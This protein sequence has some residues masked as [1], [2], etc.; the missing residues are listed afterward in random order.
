MST[1]FHCTV[2]GNRWIGTDNSYGHCECGNKFTCIVNDVDLN[3]DLKQQNEKLVEALTEIRDEIHGE[4]LSRAVA[5]HA[6]EK[7]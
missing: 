1:Q 7:L 5:K 4:L 6:L 2:C 3:K